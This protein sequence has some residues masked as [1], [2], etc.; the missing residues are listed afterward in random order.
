M[1]IAYESVACPLL[2]YDIDHM[3]QLSSHE[4]QLHFGE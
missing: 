3:A 4:H 2:N 1:N